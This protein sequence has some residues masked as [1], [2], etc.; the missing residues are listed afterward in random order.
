MKDM[1]YVLATMHVSCFKIVTSESQS[2]AAS[3]FLHA[4]YFTMFYMFCK[5]VVR[6]TYSALN[7]HGTFMEYLSKCD[8]QVRLLFIIIV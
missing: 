5:S 1:K 7:M 4:I 3:Q 2:T 8:V 6:E